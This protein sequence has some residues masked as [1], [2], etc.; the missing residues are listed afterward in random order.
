M[1]G[2]YDETK[3]DHKYNDGLNI[4]EENGF[5]F[6]NEFKINNYLKNNM[7]LIKIQIPLENPRLKI[8]SKN[9]GYETNMIII[10]EKY[11]WDN[12]DEIIKI[13]E[14]NYNCLLINSCIDGNI[15]MFETLL[16][17]YKKKI[18]CADL[19]F[20]ATQNF[21]NVEIM[22]ILKKN[23][24]NI[25]SYE[26]EYAVRCNNIQMLK[27][28]CDNFKINKEDLIINMCYYDKIEILEWY[29]NEGYELDFDK[30]AI[31]HACKNGNIQVL[32]W[33][34][35]NSIEIIYDEEALNDA[36]KF[37]HVQVFDWF[38]NNGLI[39]KYTKD[40]LN[41][42]AENGHV[43]IFEWLKNN[44]C[45]LKYSKTMIFNACYN[46]HIQILEWLRD[47]NYDFKIN[48]NTIEY[49]FK[50]GFYYFKDNENYLDAAFLNGQSKVLNWFEKNYDIYFKPKN[51]KEW[52]Y[53][54]NIIKNK[55][56]LK[57]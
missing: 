29:K 28:Y 48:E 23:G 5:Y 12:I 55:D 45:E 22:N 47:N 39:L 40:A 9:D 24:Y 32:E 34:K 53:F 42:A 51:V 6:F 11:K 14:N 17:F 1:I 25:N 54:N 15:T 56:I 18:N 41:Y 50:E 13:N 49:A 16:K 4:S 43:Q 10:C 3:N 2:H 35:N 7:F 19:I 30:C 44:D 57:N 26:Y 21:Y 8:V 27:W 20:Q 31:N 38:K 52:L 33:I 46:G 36:S 37:G